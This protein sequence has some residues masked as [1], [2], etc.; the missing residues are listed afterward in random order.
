[1][2]DCPSAHT[3]WIELIAFITGL[4]QGTVPQ[5]G[6]HKDMG[7]IYSSKELSHVAFPFI[8]SELNSSMR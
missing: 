8:V 4:N 1:M 2:K 7:T 6:S 3:S 5:D